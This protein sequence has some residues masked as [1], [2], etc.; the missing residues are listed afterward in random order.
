MMTTSTAFLKVPLHRNQ[1]KNV[2]IGMAGENEISNLLA[3][4]GVA[5]E[6]TSHKHPV[7]IVIPALGQ[8][9]FGIDVKV[10]IKAAQ[11]HMSQEQRRIKRRFC[12]ANDLQGYTVVVDV[13]ER[14]YR[15][16][17]GLYDIIEVHAKLGFKSF[18]PAHMYD[19]GSLVD[20]IKR[21]I[22]AIG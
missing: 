7:D 17:V 21:E 20:D 4:S 19:F 14:R 10:L 15:W 2:A 3:L 9:G 16:D 18:R 22:Q 8:A 1:E 13:K 5:H 12:K 6:M 11:V